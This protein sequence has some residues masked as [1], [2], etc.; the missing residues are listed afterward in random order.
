ME[1]ILLERVAKLGQM[2]EV[3]KV[4]D[5]Y[6]RNFLLKRKKAL[7]ATAENRA[8]Y[9]GMKAELEAN[10]LQ[11]KSEAAKAAEKI[12]GRDIVIIRQASESGQLFG[13]VSVRDIVA[14]LAGD[15]ITV[16]RTQVWLDAPIKA[17]GR[18]KVTI[19]VHPEVEASINVTVARSAD[20]AERIKRGEDISTRQEDQDAA[21]EAIAAAGEFF[22]PEAQPDDIVQPAA[23][24][25]A[26]AEQK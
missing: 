18:Q 8:K 25:A 14:A 19:A 1:V 21:A 6:A 3:V 20:E 16:T 26:E 12:D 17:I 11:A 4:R 7:R 9:D 15:K 5:G 22:D 10:N 24:P 13:S 2:G 23:A